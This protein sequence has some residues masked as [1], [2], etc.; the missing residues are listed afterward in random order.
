MKTTVI[1]IKHKVPYDVY[2][3]RLIRFHPKKYPQSPFANP[4]PVKK[5]DSNRDEAIKKYRE[6]LL[7]QP[8]L[9]E[10]AKKKLKGKILGC[11][12]K[13]EACHGDVLV[14]IVESK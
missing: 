1:N 6:W 12:C 14:E 2:I 9:I 11:W 3:G 7:S 8:D 5:D 13:P 4:F 10:Q